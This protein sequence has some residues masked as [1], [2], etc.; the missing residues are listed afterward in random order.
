[1]LHG[2]EEI[3]HCA[4]IQFDAQI[5]EAFLTIP[6]SHWIKLRETLGSPFRLTHARNMG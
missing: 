5:V 4:G 6:W 3:R 1:M 2:L